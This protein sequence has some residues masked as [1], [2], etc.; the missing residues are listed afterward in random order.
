MVDISP[1]QI[2]FAAGEVAPDLYYRQDLSRYHIGAALLKNFFVHPHG[3]VSNRAG[4][5][6]VMEVPQPDKAHRLID[7]SFSTEQ[8]YALVFG[9]Q[10]MHVIKDGAPVL[11]TGK[12]ITGI[13]AANP[14]VVT[15]ASHGFSNG[16]H[17][18][19]SDV[20]GMERANTGP[21]VVAN[22]ATNTFELQDTI[23]NA[24]NASGW[25]AYI[26]GGEAARVY[27]IAT[28]YESDDLPLL[29]YTQSA[30]VMTLTHPDYAP[31]NLSR[32]G[33]T[34]WTLATFTRT[35]DPFTGAGDYPGV[36]VYFEQRRTYA[37][38]EDEPQTFWFTKSGA[39]DD[40]SVSDPVVADDAAT[41][42]IAANEVNQIRH[43]IPLRKLVALTSG[44]E[45]TIDG[46]TG[47][48]DATQPTNIKQ[49][50]S[51]GSSQVR[52]VVVGDIILFV[53]SKGTIIRDLTYAWESDSYTGNNVTIL[54][55][56][57]FEQREI[58]EMAYAQ[59]PDSIVW[60][61]MSDG[62]LLGLT[63][64]REHE[65]IALH[66]H[67]TDGEVESVTS[68]SEGNEDATYFVVKRTING[69]TRRFVERLE[70]RYVADE[71]GGFFVD[72]GVT[73]DGAEVD[74]IYGLEHLNGATVAI[75]ADGRVE[76]QQ[77]V[78]G[79]S[80]VLQNPASKVHIGLPYTADLKTLDPYFESGIGR[81]K[82]AVAV[83]LMVQKT[84][85]LAVG[86]DE[87][88]LRDF[89]QKDDLA[90]ISGMLEANIAPRLKDY[91][92]IFV[93][94]AY[95]LPATINA[96]MTETRVGR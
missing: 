26:S 76:P 30:D 80:L 77:T 19:I 86:P 93:R 35:D 60:I 32:T 85:G 1:A 36:S 6:Y 33:H 13:T 11:E 5:R 73:Y 18:Y 9:H 14:A 78:S 15:A 79:G 74:T 84:R 16:D 17:V 22:A 37:A 48:I 20:I 21:F 10:T 41:Y 31:H 29:K 94:Q 49:Q 67:E 58:K 39:Y 88:S 83:R 96:V 64:L 65:V 55:K 40:H 95:P 38:S 34:S 3:G 50:A 89:K 75:L 25:E 4:M 90:L 56:H 28:P 42:T 71:T 62:Q 87:N 57:L 7:F 2:S 43:L 72:C 51:R 70:A 44:G 63:Y 91:N 24:I 23:G 47:F 92:H 27:K 8:T 81:T 45:W 69:V 12:T 59:I 66:Q 54:A 82:A 68:V 61:V 52:P 46:S 53:Q